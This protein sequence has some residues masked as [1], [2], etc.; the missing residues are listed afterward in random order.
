MRCTA[1]S[2]GVLHGLIAG[3]DPQKTI[4]FATAAAV[5]KHSIPGDFQLGSVADVELVLSEQQ[6][7]VR[8]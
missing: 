6:T 7:D 5:L 4:D 1:A 8:R 2:A 3:F